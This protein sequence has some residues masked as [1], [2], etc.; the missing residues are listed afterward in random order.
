MATPSAKGIDGSVNTLFH[1]PTTTR[2]RGK[3]LFQPLRN[4]YGLYYVKIKYEA[5]LRKHIQE[6]CRGTG[7]E[8]GTLGMKKLPINHCRK[9]KQTTINLSDI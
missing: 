1:L 4:V 2:I 7:F 8:Q 3:E 5:H 9:L 6:L